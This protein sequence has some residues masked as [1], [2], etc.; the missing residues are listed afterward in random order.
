MDDD[1]IQGGAEAPQSQ[2]T[3]SEAGTPEPSF[4]E[5]MSEA[6][7]DSLSED[8]GPP[9]PEHADAGQPRGPDGKFLPKTPADGKQANPANPDGDA[10]AQPAQ[11]PPPGQ[12][13]KPADPPKAAEDP[14]REPEGMKPEASERFRALV[15]VAKE[16]DARIEELSTQHAEVAQTVQAFQRLLVES[17]ATDAEFGALLDYTRAIKT[18]DWRAAEPLLAAQI[19][20]FRL[21]TGRDPA[22][23]DPFEQYP[24]VAEAV[25]AGQIPVEMA[26]DVVRA[27]QI[28][29]RHAQHQHEIQQDRDAQQA[30]QAQAQQATNDVAALVRQW[31][32][33]DLDWPKKQ[34]Q[35]QALAGEI[36]Q[37]T[38][39]H[40]WAD[41]LARTYKAIGEA[42]KSAA[43]PR[44]PAPAHEQPLRASGARAGARQPQ[45]MHEAIF[46]V[47]DD[48]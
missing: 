22:G 28:A 6:I 36:A 39:P 17:Q 37:T 19:Q 29:A 26:R 34:A 20:Q 38:P 40:L 25:Q 8:G 24:D 44:V 48:A 1:Q 3:D 42:M 41:A 18:G 4:A 5:Q 30:F 10:P 7:S 23:I 14:Y 35:L 13:G 21:A 9:T 31:R 12:E 43:P 33:T 27:R 15:A 11:Q 16:K 45:T 32:D 47:G 2:G 46:G